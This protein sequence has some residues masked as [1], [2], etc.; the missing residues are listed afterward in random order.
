MTDDNTCQLNQK[1]PPLS[2]GE[3]SPVRDKECPKVYV[4]DEQDNG[5][6]TSKP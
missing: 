1:K 6:C 2:R 5:A 4:H 3:E